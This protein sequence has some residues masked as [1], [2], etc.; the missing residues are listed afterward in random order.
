MAQDRLGV[1]KRYFHFFLTEESAVPQIDPLIPLDLQHYQE[2]HS[3]GGREQD[4]LA[5]N[6]AFFSNETRNAGSTY[7]K[8]L[9]L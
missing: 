9:S 8:F 2:Y 7:R 1:V 5:P 6:S 4:W 3:L